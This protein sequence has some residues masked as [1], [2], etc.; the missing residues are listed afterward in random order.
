MRYCI[1][2]PPLNVALLLSGARIHSAVHTCMTKH[3]LSCDLVIGMACAL[4]VV[5]LISSNCACLHLLR[6][7]RHDH[8]ERADDCHEGRAWRTTCGT[9]WPAVGLELAHDHVSCVR[10]YVCVCVLGWGNE[11]VQVYDRAP[12]LPAVDRT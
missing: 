12:R 6:R 10:V 8:H 11:A 3:P 2:L 9:S 4:V 5:L 7:W 1:L